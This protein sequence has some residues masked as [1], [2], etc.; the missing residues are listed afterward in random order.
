MPAY[1]ICLREST[2]RDPAAMGTYQRMNREQPAQPRPTP[3]VVYGAVE[4]LEGA[5]PD[6]VVVLQFPSLEDARAWYHSPEYQA[7][8]A[9]RMQAADHRVLIVQ[10]V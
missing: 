5:A 8:L 10:G 6:G 2:V 1:L 3:L 7:A 4:T 9:Y